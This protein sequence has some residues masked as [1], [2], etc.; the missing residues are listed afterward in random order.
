MK[1]PSSVLNC[2]EANFRLYY[3]SLTVESQL[4]RALEEYLRIQ[5]LVSPFFSFSMLSISLRTTW[6]A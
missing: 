1:T 4:K 5:R 6:I 2:N 3:Q